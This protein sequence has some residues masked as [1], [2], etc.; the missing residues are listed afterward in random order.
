[1]KPSK[2]TEVGMPKQVLQDKVVV[3]TGGAGGIGKALAQSFEKRGA[4]VGILDR[5]QQGAEAVAESLPKNRA[6]GYACDVTDPEIC[7]AVMQAILQK[8]GGVDILVN[9]AGI[10]HRSLLTE[11]EISVVQKV[12]AVNFFGAVYCTK[13]ALSSLIERQGSIVA[14]SSVAGF[15]PLIGRTGYCASKHALHGFFDTLRAELKEAG[16]HVL[17]VC[18]SFVDTAIHHTALAG[19]GSRLARTKAVVGRV[20][21]PEEVAQAIVHA[22]IHKKRLLLPSGVS[23]FSWWLS[24]IAPRLYDHI[25]IKSQVKEFVL[26]RRPF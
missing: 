8:W 21:G 18:P 2:F 3:I 11:T 23:W 5:D 16:V 24:R 25:M 15:A 17:M 13:A 26:P 19:D 12:M 20:S 1:M 10:A 22:V 7:Q 6:E 4:L 9:N 14:I